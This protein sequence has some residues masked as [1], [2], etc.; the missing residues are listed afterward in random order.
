MACEAQLLGGVYQTVN[1][2]I[3]LDKNGI[4]SKEEFVT[5]DKDGDGQLRMSVAVQL[6]GGG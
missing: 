5:S 6:R 4:I 3:D 2:V 1:N